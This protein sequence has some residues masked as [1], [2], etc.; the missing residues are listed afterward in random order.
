MTRHPLRSSKGSAESAWCL[1]SR[2]GG[3]VQTRTLCVSPGWWRL[4]S[5]GS[6]GL[7]TNPV[8]RIPDAVTLNFGTNVA[9][10]V[11]RLPTDFGP[12]PCCRSHT[13]APCPPSH[14]EGFG[15]V[16]PSELFVPVRVRDQ[17][18]YSESGHHT[19]RLV[20]TGSQIGSA[21]ARRHHVVVAKGGQ[22]QTRQVQPSEIFA[23]ASGGPQTRYFESSHTS[24]AC[25]KYL[26]Q[27][28]QP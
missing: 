7:P 13:C 4:A 8:G 23:A 15:Q 2:T 11:F 24:V 6:S 28:E 25:S 19:Q 3:G 5:S 17:P 18:R 12:E 14:S 26:S 27:T 1:I 10:G 9:L 20:V 21:A 22:V 16:Q